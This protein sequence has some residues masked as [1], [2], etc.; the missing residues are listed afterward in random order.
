MIILIFIAI[1]REAI[2]FR[3]ELR[4]AMERVACPSLSTLCFPFFLA[5][6]ENSEMLS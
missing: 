2:V 5:C 1:R 3:V 6:S 4:T